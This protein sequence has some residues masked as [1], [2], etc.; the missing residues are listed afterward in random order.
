MEAPPKGIEAPE[1]V[2]E[3]LWW[4]VGP[5]NEPAC[6]CADVGKRRGAMGSDAA[7]TALGGRNGECAAPPTIK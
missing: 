1:I 3:Y 7:G 4:R 2:H 5:G 6:E